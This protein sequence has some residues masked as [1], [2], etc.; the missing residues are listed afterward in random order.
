MI[1]SLFVT[2]P[3][4]TGKSTFCGALKDWLVS[5]DYNAAIVNLDPGSEFTPYEPD[6]DIREVISLS[7]IMSEFNLGPNGAQ[8]VGADLILENT[9]FIENALKELDDYYVIFDT[10]GQI[11]LFSFRPGS[12]LLVDKLSHG[13]AM[14]AFVTDAV[15]S[16]SP[17]GFIS[18]KML[19]GSVM[20][21]FFKPMLF[22]LNKTDLITEEDLKNI[23]SW[24]EFPDQLY[25]AFLDEKQEMV[26]DY[27]SSVLNA[28]QESRM[29]S[30]L[31][32]VSAKDF[33]GFEDIY[34]EMSLFFTGGSDADTMYRDD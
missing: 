17:S 32:S 7:Q 30:K 25:D 14:V 19:Y 11:E 10:P 2:G 18:Q 15:L 34:S 13:K 23:R 31:L 6:I 8:I 3:A 33:S 22:V 5:N 20:S 21:R 26:K 28:F 27:F 9:E 4:G 24:E 1:G 16:S 12:P 29:I